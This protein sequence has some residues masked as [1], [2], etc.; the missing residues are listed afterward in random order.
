[1]FFIIDPFL[2]HES[3]YTYF[4][5]FINDTKFKDQLECNSSTIDK[6]C[7]INVCYFQHL[8]FLLEYI[9]ILVKC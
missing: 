3:L 8:S 4:S 6:D 7:I 5:L 2:I 9:K 1:M